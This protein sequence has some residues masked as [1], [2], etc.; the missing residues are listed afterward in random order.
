[1]VLNI[2]ECI[3][4]RIPVDLSI[5][6]YMEDCSFCCL[7]VLNGLTKTCKS[8]VCLFVLPYLVSA[9]TSQC[10]CTFP[11]IVVGVCNMPNESLITIYELRLMRFTNN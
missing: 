11:S 4:V 10:G 2:C 3:G 7:L 1:M 9:K 5:F 6:G 8:S